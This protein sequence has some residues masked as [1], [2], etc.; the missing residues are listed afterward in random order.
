MEAAFITHLMCPQVPKWKMV[1]AHP[2]SAMQVN[3][4]I[5]K[6]KWTEQE[7]RLLA[8][9]YREHG[10]AWAEISRHLKGR[11]DQQCMVSPLTSLITLLCGHAIGVPAKKLRPI[12][13]KPL[14]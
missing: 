9:L 3:P 8:S 10:C 2:L 14:T 5:R 7:D 4:N 1:C 6:E 12:S 13:I 11:T